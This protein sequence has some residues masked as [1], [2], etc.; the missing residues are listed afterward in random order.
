MKKIILIIVV[1]LLC[2]SCGVKDKPEY[3]TQ[4]KNSKNIYKI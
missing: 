3:K 1:G 4:N 2:I